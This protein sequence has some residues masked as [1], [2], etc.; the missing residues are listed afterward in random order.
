MNSESNDRTRDLLG[1]V[2]A[3][4]LSL[5]IVLAAPASAEPDKPKP[6]PDD[7]QVA[8]SGQE[9]QAG[10]AAQGAVDSQG[11]AAQDGGGPHRDATNATSAAKKVSGK[12][13]VHDPSQKAGFNFDKKPAPLIREAA[14]PSK[15]ATVAIKGYA[16]PPK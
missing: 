6:K 4:G 15:G 3:L 9:S 8:V 1:V 7:G 12:P 11:R 16:P 5:G 14:S 10:L 2:A 13:E